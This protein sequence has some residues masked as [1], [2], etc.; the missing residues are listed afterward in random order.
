M[1]RVRSG[2]GAGAAARLRDMLGAQI[3]AR[4]ARDGGVIRTGA[5]ER[6][7][8]ICRHNAPV[9]EF[10]NANMQRR[11][12]RSIG[13]RSMLVLTGLVAVAGVGVLFAWLAKVGVFADP[14]QPIPPPFDF[15]WGVDI[16]V[17]V[18]HVQ[19]TPDLI[20]LLDKELD[21]MDNVVKEL[22]TN[23][24]ITHKLD[25]IQLVSLAGRRASD[26]TVAERHCQPEDDSLDIQVT[27]YT[28]R[29]YDVLVDLVAYL[30]QH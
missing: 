10:E 25:S 3:Q 24:T 2:A 12:K 20:A 1:D 27:V 11:A 19:W 30:D 23:M 7:A 6:I 18:I 14:A 9:G 8:L 5:P 21:A 13:L 28:Q 29:D 16:N 26:T 4:A 17:P 15:A 22:V